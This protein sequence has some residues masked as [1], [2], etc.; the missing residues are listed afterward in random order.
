[1]RIDFILN[2]FYWNVKFISNKKLNCTKILYKYFQQAPTRNPIF[3]FFFS[4]CQLSSLIVESRHSY[5]HALLILPDNFSI[6]PFL[7]VALM[8]CIVMIVM[9][10]PNDGVCPIQVVTQDAD[11]A[12]NINFN[13]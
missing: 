9:R 6:F 8:V 13:G 4:L 12:E 10:M 5:P 7:L 1:M 11:I 3:F 2:Y